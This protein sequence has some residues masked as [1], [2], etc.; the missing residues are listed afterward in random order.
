MDSFTRR[1]FLCLGGGALAGVGVGGLVSLTVRGAEAAPPLRPPGA[2]EEGAFLAAC[3][4]CGQCV[5]A[6]PSDTL[7]LLGLSAGLLAGSPT[8]SASEAPCTVCQGEDG[9]LCIEAC[10][11]TALAELAD[12]R[13][14][15]MGMAHIRRGRCL[16]YNG[17]MCRACWHACPYPDE[18]LYYDELLRPRI[19]EE[20][21]IGCG[22]CE[23]ACPTEP[24]AVEILPLGVEPV[25]GGGGRGGRGRGGDG[26]GGGGHRGGRG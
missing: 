24:R 5:E 26:G 25:R 15:R 8:W 3:I 21:C 16:A 13:E 9:L 17:T 4:R 7:R 14:I 19:D 10:P 12:G 6:C 22:L 2:L 18:A 23:H 11:T 1:Q 20:V